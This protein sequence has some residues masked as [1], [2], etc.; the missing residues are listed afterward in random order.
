VQLQN[1]ESQATYASYMVWF[2][3]FYL[4]IIADEESQVDNYLLQRDQIAGGSKESSSKDAGT[5]SEY[6]NSDKDNSAD[7]NNNNSVVAQRWLRKKVQTDKIKDA[8]EL[9]S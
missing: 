4:C 9:F 2:V 5:E 8:R 6:N 3:C 7:S 1:L